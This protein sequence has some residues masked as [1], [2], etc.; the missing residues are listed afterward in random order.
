MGKTYR[1]SAEAD[2]DISF[3]DQPRRLSRREIAAANRIMAR[4]LLSALPPVRKAEVVKPQRPILRIPHNWIIPE[5]ELRTNYGEHVRA[6]R[7]DL[8]HTIG[9]EILELGL[10][11][12]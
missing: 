7:L 6:S 2:V 12:Q 3:G 10:E 1:R 9:Q 8:L 5:P 4:Q 11:V